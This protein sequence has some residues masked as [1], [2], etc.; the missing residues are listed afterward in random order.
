MKP[1]RTL[2]S[3]GLCLLGTS[4]TWAGVPTPA[5]GLTAHTVSLTQI[6]LSWADNSTD[7]TGFELQRRGNSSI[8]AT[9]ATLPV[10]TTSYSDTGLTPLT[11]YLYRVRSTNGSGP[12]AYWSNEAW[13]DTALPPAAPTGLSGRINALNQFELT[14]TD[15]SSNE[16]AFE[17][18]LKG[19]G[20][21]GHFSRLATTAPNAARYTGQEALFRSPTTFRVRAIRAEGAS[22]WS[23]EWDWVPPG[24]PPAPTGLMAQAVSGREVELRWNSLGVTTGEVRI[25]R[26]V[27][28]WWHQIDEVPANSTRYTDVRCRPGLTYYYRLRA[29]VNGFNSGASAEIKVT[30]PPEAP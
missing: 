20:F 5:T 13:T 19:T 16:R 11:T 17:I 7:E 1:S 21:E 27:D 26:T 25:L 8:W 15:N 4:T 2:I 30:T 3:L 23:N 22:A 6:D 9:V 14:W 18:Y 12:A 28:G 10:N 24:T 29:Y